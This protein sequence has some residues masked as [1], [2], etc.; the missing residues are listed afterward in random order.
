M[1]A[2][3]LFLVQHA[4]FYSIGGGVSYSD[5]VFG[6]LSDHQ[7]RARPAA[8]LNS[9]VWLLWHMARTEDVAVNL[10]VAGRAQVL[11]DQWVE[12]MNI[13]WRTIGTGMVEDDVDSLTRRADIAAVKAY[14][15]AVGQRT[16]DVVRALEPEAWDEILGI[17]DTARA[18][19]AGAFAPSAPWVAGVGYRAWQGHS[20][21]VQLASSGIAHNAMHL[22]EAV[23]IRSL[24]GFPLGV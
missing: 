11:D 7:M 24:A 2:D 6:G 19:D 12:R 17:T 16:Q 15:V 18:A 8:Q 5:R 9:L 13:P 10:V 21:A 1:K 23:T 14:R 20:R 22:G 3:Q 4:R